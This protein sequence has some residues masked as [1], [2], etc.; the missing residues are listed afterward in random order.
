MKFLIYGSVVNCMNSSIIF[1]TLFLICFVYSLMLGLYI[2]SLDEKSQLN[3]AF[4]IMSAAVSMWSFSFAIANSAADYETVVLWRRFSVLGWGLVYA[5]ILHFFILLTEENRRVTKPWIYLLIYLPALIVIYFFGVSP[6]APMRYEFVNT[7]LGWVNTSGIKPEDIFFYIYYFSYTVISMYLLYNWGWNTKKQFAKK[8]SRIIIVFFAIGIVLGTLTDII[9]NKHVDFKVPQLAPVMAAIPLTA[10]FYC[11]KRYG[12]IRKKKSHRVEPGM[13]L[14][15]YDLSRYYKFVS[16]SYIMGSLA[17]FIIQYY[18]MK[19]PLEIT[20]SDILLSIGCGFFIIGVIVWFIPLIFKKDKIRNFSFTTV[21]TL[22]IPVIT[23]LFAPSGNT[24]VWVLPTALVVLSIIYNK[25]ILLYSVGVSYLLTQIYVWIKDPQIIVQI[26]KAEYMTRLFFIFIILVIAYYV[27]RVY[28]SRLKKNEKKVKLQ[29]IIAKISARFAR[30]TVDNIDARIFDMLQ[31]S[32]DFFNVDRAFVYMFSQGKVTHQ[33]CDNCTSILDYS[34]DFLDK[35]EEEWKKPERGNEVIEVPS[36]ELI[37]AKK[38]NEELSLNKNDNKTLLIFPLVKKDKPLGLIAYSF[39]RD[40]M[41]WHQGDQ[42]VLETMTNIMLDT[43]AR[44][45]SEKHIHHLAYHNPLTNLPNKRSFDEFIYEVLE[46]NGNKNG[47]LLL[48]NYKKFTFINLTFGYDYAND[49]IKETARILKTFCSGK[50]ELF[51]ISIDRFVLYVE[52][53]NNRAEIEEMCENI[54]GLLHNKIE[55]KIVKGNIGVVEIEETDTDS[56]TLLKYASIAADYEK[57]KELWNYCFF[58]DKMAAG[59][60]RRRRIETELRHIINREN[61]ASKVYL[62]YQPIID[63]KTD[64]IVSFEVLARMKSKE[65]GTV[66]PLEFIEIAEDTQQIYMLGDLIISKAFGFSNMLAAQ[67][68]TEMKISINISALQILREE[69]LKDLFTRIEEYKIEPA[70]LGIELTESVFSNDYLMLNE[71]FKKLK[72]EGIEIAI[73]DFGTG[74][75]SFARERELCVDYLKIDK[76]FID[77]LLEIESDQAI[78]GNIISMA[79]KLGHA[80]VAEGVEYESQKEFLIENN[81]DFM[82]GYLYSKPV[83]A[84]EALKMLEEQ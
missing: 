3:R 41:K 23:I 62:L 46:D 79:H 84:E 65:L 52:N 71:K 2:I 43:L 26:D 40:L 73:D 59:L 67:G 54:M 47:A 38:D 56:E 68:F 74:Y 35:Y 16:L 76:Y 6:M 4:L 80:T 25:K 39:D 49:M 28:L 9:L 22:S 18:F 55:N 60:N 81:C 53:Y 37:S 44:L 66:S 48:L 31:I 8:Q 15:E 63:L 1:S 64:K 5:C 70:L 19:T 50:V 7:A 58:S 34:S 20:T 82:Q 32:G 83:T 61:Q 77:K 10:I 45:K 42:E 51:Q 11:I 30:A 72:A 33:W 24:T 57:D 13:I 27:Y 69:F 29:K 17:F 14:S 21:V 78:T 12:L 75:S 36:A